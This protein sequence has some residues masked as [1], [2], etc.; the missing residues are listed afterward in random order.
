MGTFPAIIVY[1][2]TGQLV[3]IGFLNSLLN[4][5]KPSNHVILLVSE[6]VR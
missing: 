2:L 4:Q 3:F 5:S 6:K 1:L